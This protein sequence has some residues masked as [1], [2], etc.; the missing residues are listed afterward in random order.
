[1]ADN[2]WGLAEA[3]VKLSEVIERARTEGPQT[4][5]QRSAGRKKPAP[6]K[7]RSR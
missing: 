7:D 4:H 5:P 2:A 6:G 3:R 1:M